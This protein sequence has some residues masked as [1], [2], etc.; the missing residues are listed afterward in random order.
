MEIWHH[1]Y[2]RDS[3]VQSEELSEGSLNNINEK[4]G[5][6]RKDED[7]SEKGLPVKNFSFMEFA[8]IFHHIESGK[9]KM[10][11]VDSNL[12]SSMTI[13]QGMKRSLIYII[14]YRQKEEGKYCSNTLDRVFL[15]KEIK[16]FNSQCFY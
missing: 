16:H 10:L 1:L 8:E 7:I 6:D 15:N 13:C 5:H 3:N 11:E 12:E 4:S 9:D 2:L 14:S